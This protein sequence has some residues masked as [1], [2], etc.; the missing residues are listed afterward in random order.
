MIRRDAAL[1]LGIGAVT[2]VTFEIGRLL[3]GVADGR[4]ALVLV[5]L[6]SAALF[7][8]LWSR[9][10]ARGE[11]RRAIVL[12]QLWALACSIVTVVLVAKTG[13][14]YLDVLWSAEKYRAE[15][16]EWIKTG[17]GEESDPSRFLPLH[18]KH[19][20]AFAVL[21]FATFGILGLALGAALLHYMNFYVGSLVAAAAS[22]MLIGLVGWPPYAIVRVIGF[23]TVA[24][25]L[26]AMAFKRFRGADIDAALIRRNLLLGLALVVADVVIKT[27]VAPSW[28]EMLRG[29]LEG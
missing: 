29:L 22:P 14:R 25:A 23:V 13:D 3:H 21:A 27:L 24:T 19:F 26:T 1:A 12:A 2:P 16:F 7:H 20:L 18:A 8:P 11:L 10:V 28:G 15:M 6:L 9:T 4:V 5:P 17:I